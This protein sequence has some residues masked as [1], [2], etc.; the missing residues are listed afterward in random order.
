M[1]KSIL[2]IFIFLFPFSANAVPKVIYDS[3]QTVSIAPYTDTIKI[4]NPKKVKPITVFNPLPIST[5]N[6][7]P[8]YVKKRG[9]NQPYL[10]NPIFLFGNDEFSYKWLLKNKALLIRIDAIGMLVEVE[11]RQ[12][13]ERISHAA[14]GLKI[15]PA[16]AVDLAKQFHLKHYPVLI[17][18]QFIEQ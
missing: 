5:P 1:N 9:I 8:G 14:K 17:S 12:E 15:I 2:I 13:L 10:T 4:Y 7:S 6:L 3:G 16:P 18:K 11:S